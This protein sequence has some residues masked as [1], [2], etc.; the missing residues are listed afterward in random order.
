MR[1]IKFHLVA[2]VAAA[3]AVSASTFAIS[4]RAETALDTS[5]LA[6]IPGATETFASPA[7]TIYTSPDTVAATVTAV[8]SLLTADGWQPYSDPFGSKAENP[9]MEIMSLKKGKQGLSV[10]VT[11]APAQ[12]NATSVSYTATPIADDLPFLRDAAEIKYAPDRP[13][14]SLV[15]QSP[16]DTT[17]E[18]YRTELTARGWTAWSRKDNRE[19]S[20]DEDTSEPNNK[21]RFA[22]FVRDGRRPLMLMVRERED[23]Q[24]DVTIEPVPEKLLTL[25]KNE[26]PEADTPATAAQ[27]AAAAEAAREAN[28]AF[29]ALAGQIMEEVQ[30]ATEQA[31][32]GIAEPKVLAPISRASQ[33]TSETL[34]AL[35]GNDVP[36]PLPHTA[37]EIDFNGA[38][39]DLSFETTSSVGA[40]AKF[41]R[42]TMTRRSWAAE[43][44]PI[45]KDTMVVLRFAKGT[46]SVALTVMKFGEHARVSANGSALV[47]DAKAP[48]EPV[49]AAD[50]HTSEK[51]VELRAEEQSGLPV[52]APN[53]LSGTEKTP[54]RVSVH[55]SVAAPL[56]TV[57]AFYRRELA[58][59]GWKEESGGVAS[60]EEA[61]SAFTTPEGP[62]MLK[63]VRKSDETFA[64]L[65]LRRETAA[66]EAGMLPAKGRA[67]LMFGNVLEKTAE[68]TVGKKKVK[69]AAG[70]G[71]EKTDGPTLEVAPGK[72]TYALRMRGLP[73]VAE[74]IEVADGDI[75]G[76][77]VGPG[78]V[79]ALP[80][81]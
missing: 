4:A 70:K 2:A 43:R 23:G 80:M 38:R 53:S 11:M 18:T 72:H 36:F 75:W 7:T 58:V 71:T 20:A 16:L 62:A 25:A 76:L 31:L 37:R 10:F 49:A 69:I 33:D 26:E 64:T 56:D 40:V 57:L 28:D 1:C 50:T 52:P 42:E 3:L 51:A 30:R 34:E 55:A 65:T 45:D 27:K 61:A 5:A 9:N 54:F 12:G 67:K 66:R 19:A 77:M 44:S 68:L 32:A 6:R 59:R 17:L 78:G 46:Q 35:T 63:L 24:R 13:Y 39:G 60:A 41:Y 22:F 47:L 15:T 79:L 8:A 74:E 21:G 48:A 81:Y 29:D 73:T 14:L